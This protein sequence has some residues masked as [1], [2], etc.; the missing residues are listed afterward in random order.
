MLVA[1][2]LMFYLSIVGGLAIL[3][4]WEVKRLRMASTRGVE[5]G[6]DSPGTSV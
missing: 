1:V 2:W 5:T 3:M 6:L 4:R